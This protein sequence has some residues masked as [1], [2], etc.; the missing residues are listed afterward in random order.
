MTPAGGAPNLFPSNSR[1]NL[2]KPRLLHELKRPSNVRSFVRISTQK[3][4]MDIVF[5][6]FYIA[7]P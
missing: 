5:E 3:Q 4:W 7:T 6:T 1:T 2:A